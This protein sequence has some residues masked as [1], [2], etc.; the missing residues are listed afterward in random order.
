MGVA[1]RLSGV[2]WA[3]PCSAFALRLSALI[4]GRAVAWSHHRRAP[5]FAHRSTLAAQWPPAEA[6]PTPVCRF[7]ERSYWEE[8]YRGDGELDGDE[9]SWFCGWREL[10]PFFAELAG[11]PS[12]DDVLV[13][14]CGND[15]GNVDLFDAG[16]EDLSLFDYSGEAVA[17]ASALFGRRCVEIVEADFRSLPFDDGAF[18]VVLDKGTLDVLYITSEAALR[19]AVAELG[20]VCRPG[21][22]V[23][24]LSRVCPPE[25]LLGEF[26]AGWTPLRD[27]SLYFTDEG[28]AT[29]DLASDLFAWRRDDE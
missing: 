19:G 25:L 10:E 18:D 14:G 7:G 1:L 11:P 26:G 4:I 21:A 20:R 28:H 23:V 8:M 17:R 9:Y 29:I 13:P 24:S 3:S 5:R 6:P 2:A 22:T 12:N 27:G 16:Y 15:R